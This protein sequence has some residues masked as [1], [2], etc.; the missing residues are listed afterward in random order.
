[1]KTKIGVNPV[2]TN[3][4]EEAKMELNKK[5]A[6]MALME[7]ESGGSVKV[8]N[9]AWYVSAFSLDFRL[10]GQSFHTGTDGFSAGV[11]KS[12]TIPA[13]ADDIHLTVRCAVFFG[14]WST[15]FTKDWASPETHCYQ[16]KGSTLDTKYA[17]V[18]C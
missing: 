2:Y 7:A 16:V 14:T 3:I 8:C 11:C 15:I 17:E 4:L 12:L 1:M 5:E 9:D 10:N 6:I 13:G 18:K